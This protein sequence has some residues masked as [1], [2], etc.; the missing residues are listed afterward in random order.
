MT[1][2][3]SYK[4]RF[5]LED[6]DGNTAYAEYSS[7]RVTSAVDKYRLLLGDYSGNAS[8]NASDDT[9]SGFLYHNNQQFTTYDQ[10][11]DAYAAENCIYAA[12]FP[13]FGGFWY[14]DCSTVRPTNTYC[15]SAA[16]G[17]NAFA[18]LYWKA[19]RGTTYSLMKLSMRMRPVTY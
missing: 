10:D 8:V 13:Y 2:T 11:N 15:G 4:L 3:R 9:S 16:C 17:D 6:W 5:D 14:N 1:N 18:Y 19:W 7:F 12:S